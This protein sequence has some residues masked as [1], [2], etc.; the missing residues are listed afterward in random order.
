MHLLMVLLH[1]LDRDLSA[2][3]RTRDPEVVCL[4]LLE[5]EI[6]VLGALQHDCHVLFQ[7]DLLLLRQ[8]QVTVRLVSRLDRHRAV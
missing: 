5:L 6:S 7:R 3:E 2:Y 8:V 1:S 4:F